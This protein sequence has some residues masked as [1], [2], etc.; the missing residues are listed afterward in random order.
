MLRDARELED[1]ALI[2]CDLCVV[3]AGAAGITLARAFAGTGVRVCLLESGG[4]EFEEQ[5]QDLYK[6]QNVGLPYFDLDTCRLR[7]FGGTTNHW[8]GRCRPFDAIDF[9]A[10]DWVPDSGWPITLADLE[11]FYRQAQEICQLGPFEYRGE[12]WLVEN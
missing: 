3:G 7:L 8:E 9:E 11:P 2:E 4:L 10:R 1:G 5:V 6:G 12:D